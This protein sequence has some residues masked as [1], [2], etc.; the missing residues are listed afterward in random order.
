MVQINR[1]PDQKLYEANFCKH[2]SYRFEDSRL[3]DNYPR[4]GDRHR[5]PCI[6]TDDPRID[7]ES[8]QE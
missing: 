5:Q 2:H 7:F 3:T 6:T 8:D 4:N 1:R